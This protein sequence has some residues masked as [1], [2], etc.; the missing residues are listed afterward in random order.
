MKIKKKVVQQ[1]KI[2]GGKTIYT[3]KY[4]INVLNKIINNEISPETEI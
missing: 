4:P 2:E 1:K 3:M